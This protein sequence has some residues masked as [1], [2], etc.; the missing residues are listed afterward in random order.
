MKKLIGSIITASVLSACSST[1]KISSTEPGGS[2]RAVEKK[3]LPVR[4]AEEAGP[5]SGNAAAR[6]VNKN[7][8]SDGANREKSFA[9]LQFKYA[10]L[11][12]VPVEDIENNKLFEFV[13]SWYGTPYRYG[14]FSKDGVDCSGFTQSF[15][16]SLYNL[17]LPRISAEQFNQSKRISKKQLEEGDLVFFKT[18]G[19]TISHVGVYLRNNKFV[20]ASTSGGVMISDLDEDYFARRYAGAGRVRN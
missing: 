3:K 20:H 11:L 9:A 13:D 12:D 10:I 18:S 5:T 8:I 6:G 7:K 19:R 16:T 15:F 4:Y 1:K 17:Q 14:G 2:T